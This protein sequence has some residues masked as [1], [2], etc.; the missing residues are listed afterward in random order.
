MCIYKKYFYIYIKNI[1]VIFCLHFYFLA[2]PADTFSYV[3]FHG[4]ANKFFT[5][6]SNLILTLGSQCFCSFTMGGTL[7]KLHSGKAA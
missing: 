3:I 2:R 5:F 1:L 4:Y 6:M 7:L